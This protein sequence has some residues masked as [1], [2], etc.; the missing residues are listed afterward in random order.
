MEGGH[1]SYYAEHGISP[2]RYEMAGLGEHFDRRDAL[3]RMA[4]L[5]PVAFRG[6]RVLEV[7]PGSGQNSLYVACQHPAHYELVEPNPAG[8]RDIKA[9]YESVTVPHTVPTLQPVRL[10]E[11]A[12]DQLFDIVLCEN[13]LGSL[14][15]ELAHIDKLAGLVAPGGTLVITAVPLA[16]FFPNVMRK[17]M[18]IRLTRD[19]GN[20][21]S[22]TADLLEAFSPHLAT[23]PGMTR[24]HEDWV[25]DC[26]VNPHYLRVALPFD[27]LVAAVGEEMEVLSSSPRFQT[28]WRWFKSMTGENRDYNKRFLDATAA[29]ILNFLDYRR[30]FEAAPAAVAKELEVLFAG[31]YQQALDWETAFL[32]D[33]DDRC[34]DVG[35]LLVETLTALS[36]TLGALDPG[37][38]G[39]F[40]ELR[41]VWLQTDITTEAVANMKQF[42]GLFGR[43]TVYVSFTRARS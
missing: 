10:E 1:L 24:S 22:K 17:L 43:E 34:H 2:V 4:G 30:E 11:Y 14:P 39:V 13:W 12:P 21:Q 8:L 27:T 15:E 38:K 16:G 36:Q 26:M 31:G 19:N 42:N 6:A 23:I 9:A 41:D 40:E 37:F 29:S 7:A 18:A 3:Y 25:H 5:S 32:E 28:D 20:F 35:A 33:D